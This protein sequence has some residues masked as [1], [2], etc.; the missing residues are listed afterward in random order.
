[1]APMILIF[2]LVGNVFGLIVLLRK[3]LVKI[4]PRGMYRFLFVIDVINLLSIII[5]YLHSAFHINVQI[6]S[7]YVCKLYVYLILWFGPIP[8]YIL[9]YISVEKIIATK[10]PA[11]KYI[12]RKTKTQIIYFL[13]ILSFNLAY[14]LITLFN[15]DIIRMIPIDNSTTVLLCFTNDYVLFEIG[16]WMDIVNRIIIPTVLMILSSI[17]FLNSIW[18]LNQRIAQNFGTNQNYKKQ[19]SRIISL[20]ILNISYIIFSLPISISAFFYSPNDIEFLVCFYLRFISYSINFY[21]IIFTNS[22]FRQEFLSIF[23]K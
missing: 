5:N 14:N 6:I 16:N 20:I 8:A 18:N 7:K 9:L 17:I 23:N 15:S 13:I 10:Y 11:R 19:I 3:K 21:I 1:M 22:L 12:L 4:G 2:G